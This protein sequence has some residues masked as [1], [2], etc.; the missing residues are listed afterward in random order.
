MEDHG[1]NDYIVLPELVKLK[2]SSWK[3]RPFAAI[4]PE[5]G[6]L[7]K[8]EAD[9]PDTSYNVEDAYNTIDFGLDFCFGVEMSIGSFVPMLHLQYY[10]G[11]TNTSQSNVTITNATAT[12]NAGFRYELP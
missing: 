2:P 9:W 8:S 1:K 12:I 6:V 11:L 10:K 4:G 3:V 7:I 5:M